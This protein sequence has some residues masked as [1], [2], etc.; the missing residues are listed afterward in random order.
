MN[1]TTDP[2][3]RECG[4]SAAESDTPVFAGAVAFTC[5]SCLMTGAESLATCRH[6]LGVHW[7][8]Q[9]DYN[10]IEANAAHAARVMRNWEALNQDRLPAPR[11]G[12]S[13]ESKIVTVADGKSTTSDTP[14]TI[15]ASHRGRRR[16]DPT[17]KRASA[18]ARQRAYRERHRMASEQS[19]RLSTS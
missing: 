13:A 10:V 18:V 1:P 14:E 19:S 15:K 11:P 12:P 4:R 8:A 5:S 17:S 16:V 6:C 7:D 3:C 9:C 2:S